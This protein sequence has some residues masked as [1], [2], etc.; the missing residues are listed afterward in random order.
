MKSAGAH[1]GGH[2][3][4]PG[5]DG[6]GSCNLDSNFHHYDHSNY[7]Q[8]NNIWCNG[9]EPQLAQHHRGNTINAN[10]PA[11]SSFVGGFCVKSE[12]ESGQVLDIQYKDLVQHD[13]VWLLNKDDGIYYPIDRDPADTNI[14]VQDGDWADMDPTQGK[15]EADVLLSAR[16]FGSD[17][18]DNRSGGGGGC[19]VG[20]GPIS[21]VGL[22]AFW[23]WRRGDKSEGR[24]DRAM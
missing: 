14:L 5:H 2:H 24:I 1:G 8:Q 4:E 12:I 10:L 9:S 3:P 17:P 6:G 19:N 18:G 21:L 23:L 20:F 15:V 16:N 7:G 11:D 13:K 22:A